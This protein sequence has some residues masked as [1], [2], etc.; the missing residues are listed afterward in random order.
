M[1]V[2]PSSRGVDAKPLLALGEKN[3]KLEWLLAEAKL[4]HA[5]LNL[6]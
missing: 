4:D 3:A 2:R 6:L 1:R 5:D